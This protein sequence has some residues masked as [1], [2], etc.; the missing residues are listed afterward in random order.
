MNGETDLNLVDEMRT[1]AQDRRLPSEM[2]AMIKKR[3][4]TDYHIADVVRYFRKAFGLSLAEAKTIRC[5]WGEIV[6]VA[7]FDSLMQA[8]ISAHAP[9]WN[10]GSCVQRT[11][12]VPVDGGPSP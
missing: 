3:L 2:F 12:S 8:A 4:G 11:G 7:L 5:V 1:M 9:F 10:S 6:D